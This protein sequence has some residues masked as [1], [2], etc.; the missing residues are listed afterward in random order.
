MSPRPFLCSICKKHDV[1]EGGYH[2]NSKP[3]YKLAALTIVEHGEQYDEQHFEQHVCG[4]ECLMKLM[5]VEMDKLGGDAGTST[6][7]GTA[8][9]TTTP[10]LRATP[11]KIGGQLEAA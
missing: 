5:N 8:S 7:L 6:A 2:V 4:R 9:T 3:L 1:V 10:A 11:P